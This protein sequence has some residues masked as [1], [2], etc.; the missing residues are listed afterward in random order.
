MKKFAA[1]FGCFVFFSAT[2]IAQPA[3]SQRRD[4]AYDRD[5]IN[6]KEIIPYDNIREADVFW[7]KRVWRNIDFREKMNLPF[8][9]PKEPFIQI[10]MDKVKNNELT[11]FSALD[12][13]FTQPLTPQQLDEK[14]NRTDTFV[15]YDPDTYEEIVQIV[16]REFDP[17]SVKKLRIK[18]DWIFDEET[19]TMVVR[20]IGVAPI[21][22]RI[23]PNTG[24]I[25]GD[26]LMFW[27]YYP[28]LRPI[29]VRHEV[30]NPNND[31]I[32]MSWEDLFE[33]RMFSS[34]IIKESNV[35]DRFIE[36]YVT[37]IDA[38][39]ESERIKGEIF[40]FEHNLWEF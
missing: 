7:E 11:V 1:L 22:D 8:A 36:N 30:F 32:R 9:Y 10:V 38:V 23:D 4:R 25:L 26:E 29:L 39:L 40:E 28:D 15:T 19:S 24:D 27:V 18:E 35:Y 17:T 2:L 37:G 5:I 6:E 33:M 34:Y 3:E 14:Y 20:V 31:A 16:P 12:D 13:E 21:K